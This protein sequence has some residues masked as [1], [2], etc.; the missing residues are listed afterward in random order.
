MNKLNNLSEVSFKHNPLNNTEQ[1]ADIRMI[2]IA[3][4]GGLKIF[5]RSKLILNER[6]G[7]ELDYLKMFGSEWFE[8]C[9]ETNKNNEE[10]RKEF[11]KMH[12]RYFE[13]V[14]SKYLNY[15]IHNKFCLL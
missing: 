12:P 4:I 15:Q 13:L 3:K 1:P 8:V 6:R 9:D 5:N 11:F 7:C 2:F 10:R 14:K